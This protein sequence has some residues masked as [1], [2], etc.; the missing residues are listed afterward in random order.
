MVEVTVVYDNEAKGGFVPGWGFSC[1]VE[2]K[3]KILFDT[4]W[5]GNVLLHNLNLAGVEDFDYIFLSHQ[6][7]D[8]IGGLN[9]VIDRT[10]YV[11]VPSSFSENLKR[12]IG[13]KAELIEVELPTEIDRG[14]YTT[15]ALGRIG[16]QS[17]IVE[18]AKGLLVLT[19]CSHPGLDLILATAERFGE[20]RVVMGGFHGFD[21]VDMLRRYELVIPCHCTMAKR[22]ILRLGNA[23]ECYAGCSFELV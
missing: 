5:D 18:L 3:A 22:E 9:H 23:K 2:S 20:V 21:R 16:E 8:H 11:V 12:E 17:L 7:W 10:S 15:G 4:G 13:R 1:Y 14:V 6:H 19:G